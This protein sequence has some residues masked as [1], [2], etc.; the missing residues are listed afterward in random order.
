NNVE[1]VF[2]K[3][4]AAGTWTLRVRGAAVPGTPSEPDSTRQGYALVATYADC[5]ASLAAP[6]NVAAAD[7]GA[8]GIGVSWDP[9]GGASRY[10]IY[11]ANG[12]C[13][14]PGGDFHYLGQ[15]ASTG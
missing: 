12:T 1:E 9:V 6:A 2:L 15:S 3:T 14:A 11:R 5:A 13:A 8:A 4:P 7:G 10:Q